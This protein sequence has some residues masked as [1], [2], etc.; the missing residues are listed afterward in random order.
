MTMSAPS[1]VQFRLADRLAQVGRVMLVVLRSPTRLDSTAS[2]N[3]PY[4]ADDF[5]A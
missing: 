1:A 4:N 5:A 2:R 3:G